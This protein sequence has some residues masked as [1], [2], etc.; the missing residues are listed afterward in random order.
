MA[1]GD[2]KGARV[3]VTGAA[4]G[5]GLAVARAMAE[6]GAHVAFCGLR[7]GRV[8]E[9]A[10]TL[11]NAGAASVHG[12]VVDVTDADAH[13][14]WVERAADA[15]G[16]IDI[17]WNN[18]GLMLP[19]Q[20]V[21]DIRWEDYD[22]LMAVNLHAVFRGSQLFARRM[23]QQGT[24]ALIVN[25]GSENSLFHAFPGG[26]AYVAS[27]MAVRGL[28][29]TLRQDV[30]GHI[31]VKLLCPGFVQT[32]LGPDAQM[33]HGMDAA[34]FADIVLPQ[35]LEPDR[36]YVASHGYNAVRVRQQTDAMLAD[37]ERGSA[38]AEATERYDTYTLLG[39]DNDGRPK[40]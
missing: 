9:A 29:H 18:A 38:P 22:R 15:M 27:K 23:I 39:L 1:V 36:F 2:F 34:R 10:D 8:D 6:R 7:A 12:D 33:R 24:P 37:V 20:P 14:A 28:T 31:D 17:G 25:T 13:T 40:G 30:P 3:A 4:T 11:R 5:L 32:E 21:Q 26:A 19:S 35:F 16:G